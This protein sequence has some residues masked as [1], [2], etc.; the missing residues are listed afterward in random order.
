MSKTMYL[1]GIILTIILG[2]FLQYSFCCSAPEETIVEEEKITEKIPV[3]PVVE[4]TPVN[5]FTISENGGDFSYTVAQD[6]INFALS[7][8]TH[9]EPVKTEVDTGILKLASYLNDN[10]NKV[11][12]ITGYYKSSENYSGALPNLGV[13]RATDVKNYLV[14]K[15]VNSKQINT[16][17]E[18]KEDVLLRD[19]TII[20]PLSLV[21][22]TDNEADKEAAAEEL[23]DMAAR[24]KAD[25]LVLYF[26]TNESEI[27]LSAE[28]RQKVAD[29]SRYLD[30]VEG[31]TCLVVGHTDSVGRLTSNMKLGQERADFAKEYLIQNGIAAAKIEASSRG[32]KDPIASNNTKE[33]QAKNRRTVITLK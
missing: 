31:A 23:E 11:I 26:N 25:P 10:P 2:T 19:T 27:N 7:G 5:A 28:Q 1:L 12:N 8:E 30:K 16:F 15:G 14:A 29:I 18:I 22:E 4:E 32:P 17:G 6:N 9:L 13:A 33:G 24:I 20:G 3:A 21:V